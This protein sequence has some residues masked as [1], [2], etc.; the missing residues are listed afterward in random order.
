MHGTMVEKKKSKEEKVKIVNKKILFVM[1]ETSQRY[2]QAGQATLTHTHTLMHTHIGF[3]KGKAATSPLDVAV[4]VS[5]HGDDMTYLSQP[6]K[7]SSLL[8][9]KKNKHSTSYLYSLYFLCPQCCS[10]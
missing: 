4:R 3:F 1:F 5:P 9:K 8:L 2:G 7:N 6:E 10:S